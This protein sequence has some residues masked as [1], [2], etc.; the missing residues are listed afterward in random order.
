MD[1]Q[2]K[3]RSPFFCILNPPRHGRSLLLDMLFNGTYI[4]Y[5]PTKDSINSNVLVI[6]ITYNSSQT[7]FN[8]ILELESISTLLNGIWMRVLLSLFNIEIDSESFELSLKAKITFNDIMNFTKSYFEKDP[9]YSYDV[10]NI[11]KEKNIVIAI[12]EFSNVFD[13]MK[14]CFNKEYW[15]VSKKSF[16]SYLNQWK[17]YSKTFR[18][19]VITGFNTNMINQL[20]SSSEINTYTVQINGIT[21][22]ET[23]QII[24][25]IILFYKN[26]GYYEQFPWLILECVKSTPGLLG[27]WGNQ[28]T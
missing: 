15:D 2:V 8:P 9:F 19:F 26:N 1:Q 16:L 10:N 12:D 27:H 6:P 5:F 18:H 7:F 22:K 17:S 11:P 14:R 25:E 28:L 23:I 13:Y 20:E 21:S 24:M 3:E 4:H